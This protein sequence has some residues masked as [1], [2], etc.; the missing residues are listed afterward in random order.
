MDNTESTTCIAFIDKKISHRTVNWHKTKF[1]KPEIIIT[2]SQCNAA[3]YRN[4]NLNFY[5][6]V[7]YD[8]A[9]F[10]SGAVIAEGHEI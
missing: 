8:N 7:P 9:S 1:N 5:A 2:K 6:M 3:P 4:Y 10:K